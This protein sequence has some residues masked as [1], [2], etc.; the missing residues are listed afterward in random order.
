MFICNG[1]FIRYQHQCSLTPISGRWWIEWIVRFEFVRKWIH[2]NSTSRS[3]LVPTGSHHLVSN[4]KSGWRMWIYVDQIWIRSKCCPCIMDSAL[5]RSW[6]RQEFNATRQRVDSDVDQFLEDFE[7]THRA[8][9]S[10]RDNL[11]I[12]HVESNG[13]PFEEPSSFDQ[14]SFEE[15]CLPN[16]VPFLIRRSRPLSFSFSSPHTMV[17]R[18]ELKLNSN[19][20]SYARPNLKHREGQIANGCNFMTWHVVSLLGSPPISE[21]WQLCQTY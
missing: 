9:E 15:L 18:I 2:M 3:S 5:D 4:H 10:Q 6:V 13:V 7:I 17:A 20:N 12:L 14:W 1:W 16:G 11:T 21:G 19:I 8:K